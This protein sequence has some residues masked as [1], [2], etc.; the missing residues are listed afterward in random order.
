MRE[1]HR[2]RAS[3]NFAAACGA[4]EAFVSLVNSLVFAQHKSSMTEALVL[5]DQ[6]GIGGSTMERLQEG[7]VIPDA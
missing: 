3:R 6:D 2:G 5:Q 7:A 1:A 4:I